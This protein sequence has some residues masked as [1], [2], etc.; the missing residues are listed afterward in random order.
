MGNEMSQHFIADELKDLIFIFKI[1]NDSSLSEM[2]K[3]VEKIEVFTSMT[4]FFTSE[5][6]VCPFIL[7]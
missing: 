5:L 6:K 3:T 7:V 4:E 2:V 1:S